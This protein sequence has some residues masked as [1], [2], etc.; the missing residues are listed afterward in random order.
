MEAICPRL[1]LKE[2]I[3]NWNQIA[4]ELADSPRNR[5]SQEEILDKTS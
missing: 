2:M 1:P 3:E 4:A 5:K